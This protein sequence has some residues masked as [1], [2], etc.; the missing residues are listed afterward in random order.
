VIKGEVPEKI[1]GY[2]R[3]QIHTVFSPLV[4]KNGGDYKLTAIINNDKKRKQ[5]I[6]FTIKKRD[7]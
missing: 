1:K 4:A 6:V 2:T 7:D 5:E 3:F